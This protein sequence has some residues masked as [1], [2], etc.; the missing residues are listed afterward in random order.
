[1]PRLSFVDIPETQRNA[2]LWLCP[3]AGFVYFYINNHISPTQILNLPL[4]DAGVGLDGAAVVEGVLA[5]PTA[6][7]SCAGVVA[8]CGVAFISGSTES[9]QV[10]GGSKESIARIPWVRGAVIAR[11]CP[12][13]IF[14]CTVLPWT[15]V[16]VELIDG[17][18]CRITDYA[19][20]A[21]ITIR[22]QN[23]IRIML[24]KPTHRCRYFTAIVAT[25][26]TRT[27]GTACRDGKAILI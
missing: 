24:L 10:D 22:M 17:I 26:I 1:M 25:L 11:F 6:A 14:I 23:S 5:V 19:G 7:P 18:P 12:D 8:C 13:N 4:E 2:R 21:G 15:G 3:Y 27:A 20:T 16:K 9:L